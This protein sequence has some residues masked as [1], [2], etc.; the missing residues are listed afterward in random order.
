MT[1]LDLTNAP[2]RSPREE[3]RGLCMLPRMIDIARG[4]LAGG[5]P[6]EYQIGREMSLSAIVLG[7]FNMSAAEFV[8][9]VRDANTDEEVAERLWPGATVPP[10]KLSARLRRATVADVPVQLR[11]DFDRLYGA[12][13]PPDR[14]VLDILDADDARAFAQ[15]IEQ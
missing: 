6:G 11:A 7:A 2:P 12:D 14:R 15:K 4:K 13:L 9:V 3:L 5:N 1:P 10:N 8:E